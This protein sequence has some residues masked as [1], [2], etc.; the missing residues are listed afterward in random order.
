MLLVTDHRG[1]PATSMAVALPCAPVATNTSEAR[2]AAA[3][4]RSAASS[5]DFLR[6]NSFSSTPV[7]LSARLPGATLRQRIG[8]LSPQRKTP[9]SHARDRGVSD[10]SHS[11]P[12]GYDYYFFF[13]F[14]HFFFLAISTLLFFFFFLHFFFFL[15]VAGGDRVPPPGR[16]PQAS[17]RTRFANSQATRHA[18]VTIVSI[19]VARAD[20]RPD[21]SSD[22]PAGLQDP[23][24]EGPRPRGRGRVRP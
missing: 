19:V 2:S 18:D 14:L 9:R 20:R 5:S 23:L 12:N 4:T 13:F 16:R 17:G 11:D 1:A 15:R 8:R 22:G 6:R 7:P 24:A 3:A 21:A 10:S